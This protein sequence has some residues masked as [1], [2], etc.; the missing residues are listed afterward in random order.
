MNG[1]DNGGVRVAVA[2]LDAE[3]FD[4]DGNARRGADAI[5]EAAAD[6]ARVVVLPELLSTAY[7]MDRA[8]VH[9]AAEQVTEG[10]RGPCV[11][12]WA[13]AARTEGVA[14]VAGLA[15]RAGEQHFNSVVVID[16]QGETREVYRKVHLFNAE[17]GIFDPG[18]R[19]L[20][21][22]EIAGLRLGVLVCYDLRFPEAL[23]ILALRGAQ[24]VAVPTAWVPGFDHTPTPFP[25]MIPQV[26]N[27]IVQ[28][29]LN[30]VWLAAAGRAG[31]DA[32]V[33]LLGSSLVIDP[34]GHP[35]QGPLPED[36][37]A[38]ATCDVQPQ[39]VENSRRRGSLIR[40]R[41]DRRTDLYGALL[42]YEEPAVPALS[43]LSPGEQKDR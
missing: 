1:N 37:V 30:Q 33:R 23:R 4:V 38:I 20:P 11:T 36:A 26:A 5:G 34:Y 3:P 13:R 2:Q 41:E 32:G 14:V 8:A 24:L 43:P 29:N 9:G 27:A 31:T 35:V 7:V 12:A 15:E 16:E 42:G 25:N 22:V 6:G 21:I 10:V 18:D 19:G 17:R 28:A 40:P 39:A